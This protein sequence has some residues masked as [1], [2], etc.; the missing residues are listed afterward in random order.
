MRLRTGLESHGEEV[1]MQNALFLMVVK[2]VQKRMPSRRRTPRRRIVVDW[3]C[4]R[5]SFVQVERQ[6]QPRHRMAFG[7]NVVLPD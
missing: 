1:L 7:P 2:R 4:T 3:S 6:R 5:D